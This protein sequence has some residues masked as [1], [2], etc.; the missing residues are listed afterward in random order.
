MCWTA[1]LSIVFSFPASKRSRE[2]PK[3]LRIAAAADLQFAMHDLAAAFEQSGTAVSVTYGS[4]GNFFS[5]LESGAPFDLFFSADAAYPRKLESDGL[6][7]PGTRCTYAVGRLAIW[8]P[9]DSSVNLQSE[10]WKALLNPNVQKISI[11]N[12]SHAPYGRAAVAALR[13]AGL[14]ERIRAKLIFGEN[15][16]QAAQF[17]QSGNAQAGIVAMSFAVSPAMKAGKIWEVPT[18]SYPPI[19]QAAVILK[20]SQDKDAAKLFVDFVKSARGTEILLR[21]GFALPRSAATGKVRP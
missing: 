17:V 12:P 21:N 1:L 18:N 15:V 14:Y 7:E 10:G 6:T 3:E 13:N 2:H 4:S 20:G 9:A 8:M 11:A 5:Q 16:S 19:E